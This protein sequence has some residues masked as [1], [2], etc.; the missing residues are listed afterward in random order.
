MF[1][2]SLSIVIPERWMRFIR[3][4][5]VEEPM[6]RSKLRMLLGILISVPSSDLCS[7]SCVETFGLTIRLVFHNRNV[8]VN[9]VS[10]CSGVHEEPIVPAHRALL[11]QGAKRDGGVRKHSRNRS[12]FMTYGDILGSRYVSHRRAACRPPPPP[13]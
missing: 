11:Y 9:S 5:N 1:S 8:S 6:L 7:S 10:T 12:R 2:Q 3:F 13:S 4:F